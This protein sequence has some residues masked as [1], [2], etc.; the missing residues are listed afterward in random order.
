MH[1][2]QRAAANVFG[3]IVALVVLAGC[4]PGVRT[5][6][7]AAPLAKLLPACVPI[8]KPFLAIKVR[9]TAVNCA[10]S[11]AGD[12]ACWGMPS[13]GPCSET[14][15]STPQRLTQLAHTRDVASSFSELC[16]ADGVGP[17][18]CL[19]Y[20]K[21]T[22]SPR[23]GPSVEL[24]TDAAP[25]CARLVGGTVM[26]EEGGTT[27]P[28]ANVTRATSLSCEGNTC[29]AVTHGRVACWGDRASMIG[30]DGNGWTSAELVHA[31]VPP[32]ETI[33]FRYSEACVR[34]R[35]GGV[36]C[37][38]NERVKNLNRDAGARALYVDSGLCVI[39]GDRKTTCMSDGL[40]TPPVLDHVVDAD[41]TCAAYAD[42]HVSC[43]GG[44][45]S[46]QLGDGAPID[47]ATPTRVRGLGE[48]SELVMDGDRACAIGTTKLT[49]WGWYARAELA[50]PPG[51]RVGEPYDL[52]C[53]RNANR[54]ISCLRD[55]DDAFAF[56]PYV[57]VEGDPTDPTDPPNPWSECYLG[58][59]DEIRCGYLALVD[60]VPS[61]ARSLLRVETGYCAALSDGRVGCVQPSFA[62]QVKEFQLVDG[63]RGVDQLV[64]WRYVCAR[65]NDG[66]IWC[67]WKA[68]DGPSDDDGRAH[69]VPLEP[70]SDVA[71]ARS[72]ARVC[73]VVAGAVWCWERD[74][75]PVKTEAPFVATRVAVS[76]SA[77][78]A[79]DDHGQ[80]WCWGDDGEGLIGQRRVVHS[81]V[82]VRVTGIGR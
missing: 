51:E 36:Y 43:H 21:R 1:V 32:A 62:R 42:G 59:R 75:Q 39:G 14:S 70:A 63:P 61:P 45:A 23:F 6:P 40:T 11:T 58:T 18:M 35:R 71:V 22:W 5:R 74:K 64:G 26:C 38:G 34:M 25:M 82:P 54:S 48:V 80:V 53:A 46:G 24:A 79:L 15:R 47:Y 41:G 16:A 60:H 67:W 28:V 4:D 56:V 50:M 13:S 77:T 10:I 29:C 8:A 12:V 55:R 27:W 31:E 68:E 52:L 66:K 9:S 7:Q 33:R 30:Y 2:Q 20:K 65:S 49:C 73:A 81:R 44:N 57:P 37:W 17:T 19:G 72:Y 3:C 69:Q 78:C 76:R